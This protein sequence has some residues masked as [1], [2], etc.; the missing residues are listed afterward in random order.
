MA[1]DKGD[2]DFLSSSAFAGSTKVMTSTLS[3]PGA[4]LTLLHHSYP[5]QHLLSRLLNEA[6]RW[7]CFVYLFV[8]SSQEKQWLLAL[9]RT[10]SNEQSVV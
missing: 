8:P 9:S 2:D 3:I 7:T 4:A 1:I 10:V 6:G 5:D